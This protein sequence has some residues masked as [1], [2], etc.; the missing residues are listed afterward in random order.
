MAGDRFVA[1]QAGAGL[2]IINCEQTDLDHLADLV[3]NGEIGP[4]LEATLNWA[5][6]PGYRA[7]E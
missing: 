5:K 3:I 7:R 4:T 6:Q 2:I 1:K